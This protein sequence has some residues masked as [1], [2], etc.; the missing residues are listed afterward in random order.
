MCV[1]AK[2]I[3]VKAMFS[4][5]MYGPSIP[6]DWFSVSRMEIASQH[7]PIAARSWF[8]TFVHA[9][10]PQITSNTNITSILLVLRK[11]AIPFTTIRLY[12]LFSTDCI[13]LNKNADIE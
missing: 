13:I 3:L 11:M 8:N 10:F 9:F 7:C 1:F 12:S 4:K 2:Y 5:W 6:P